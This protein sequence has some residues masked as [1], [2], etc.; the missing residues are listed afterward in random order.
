M[1]NVARVRVLWSGPGVVGPGVSTFYFN[2][3]HSGFLADLRAFY[4]S[5]RF[6]HPNTVAWDFPNTGDLLDVASGDIT[7]TWTEP[8]EAQ[9]V[10]AG[11]GQH[12]QGVGMRLTWSTAGIRNHRRVRGST[13]LCPLTLTMYDTDGTIVPGTVTVAKTAAD[14]LI[15]DSAGEFVIYSRKGAIPTGQAS[16]VIGSGAPDRVSW[17]RSRRT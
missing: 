5:L 2:E 12:A 15:T 4:Y 17:L 8:A 14:Q 6:L 10:A 16:E 13:F 11:A 1:A 9:L 7:G 3:I